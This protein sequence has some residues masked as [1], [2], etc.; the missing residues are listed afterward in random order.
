[1]TS[2]RSGDLELWTCDLEGRDMKQVTSALGYDGGAYFSHDGQW[3]VFRATAFTPG[4]EAA[5]EAEYKDLLKRWLVRPTHMEIM[6]CR[7]DGRERHALTHLGKASFAPYFFPGDK[8]V[9]FASNY[10]DP[11]REGRNFDL[12]A[13]GV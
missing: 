7:P 4:K 10:A 12:Y 3:L 1:F 2:S 9:I 8:R 11:G 5:E 6:L 13:I